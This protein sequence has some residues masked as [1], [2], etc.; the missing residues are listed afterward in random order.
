MS[1]FL[2]FLEDLPESQ[3]AGLSHAKHS[4]PAPYLPEVGGPTALHSTQHVHLLSNVPHQEVASLAGG[5]PQGVTQ[6]TQGHLSAG[7]PGPGRQGAGRWGGGHSPQVICRLTRKTEK[8]VTICD[9]SVSYVRKGKITPEG[10]S[11]KALCRRWHLSQVLKKIG[12][13][14]PSR[15]RKLRLALECSPQLSRRKAAVSCPQR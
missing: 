6:M 4:E 14:R 15:G 3:E 13:E 5:E 9:H 8:Q 10:E 11:E 2:E 7:L 12:K 1:I